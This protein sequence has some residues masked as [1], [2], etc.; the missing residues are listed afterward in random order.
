L[1]SQVFDSLKKKLDD[2]ELNLQHE[3]E[4]FAQEQVISSAL[5]SIEKNILKK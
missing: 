1:Q 2:L 3:K 5:M 4:T